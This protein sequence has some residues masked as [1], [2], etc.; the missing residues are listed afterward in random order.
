MLMLKCLYVI[1][2]SLYKRSSLNWLLETEC[3]TYPFI[4]NKQKYLVR[5]DDGLRRN[6]LRFCDW[7]KNEIVFARTA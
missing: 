1:N 3:R 7:R 5:E 6:A 2:V 4:V